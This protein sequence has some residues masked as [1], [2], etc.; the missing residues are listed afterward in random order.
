[1]NDMNKQ[2]SRLAVAAK[3]K[4]TIKSHDH[5]N[6]LMQKTVSISAAMPNTALAIK[7]EPGF[8]NMR[9]ASTHI[10]GI[11]MAPANSP[12]METAIRTV[13]WLGPSSSSGK[14]LP[15]VPLSGLP[16]PLVSWSRPL[17]SKMQERQSSAYVRGRRRLA[18]A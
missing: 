17:C 16:Q 14:A 5:R 3:A 18:R 6:S 1:M 4:E 7:S 13:V 10:A 8:G 12:K 2:N 11:E 15:H 9:T